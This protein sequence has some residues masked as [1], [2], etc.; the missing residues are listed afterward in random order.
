[1][2]DCWMLRYDHHYD[3]PALAGEHMFTRLNVYT[4]QCYTTAY[5]E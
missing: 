1:M 3:E 4:I 5:V 2:L